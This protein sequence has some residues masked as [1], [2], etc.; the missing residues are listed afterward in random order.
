MSNNIL[1]KT[2]NTTILAI[3]TATILLCIVIGLFVANRNPGNEGVE[4][5]KLE[6]ISALGFLDL[7]NNPY[8]IEKLSNEVI[9]LNTWSTSCSFCIAE[10]PHFTELQEMYGNKIAVLAINRDEQ[11]ETQFEFFKNT[12]I[13][14]EGLVYLQDKDDEFYYYINGIGMPETVFIDETGEIVTHIKGPMTVEKM[15]EIVD[16]ILADNT[17]NLE[18]EEYSDGI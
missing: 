18:L 6:E 15:K 16:A 12:G 11:L 17:K 14:R 13:D 9:I 10:L 1:S 7:E 3:I 4:K 2:N 8:E 5:N